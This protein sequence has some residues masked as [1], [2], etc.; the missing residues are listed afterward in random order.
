MEMLGESG[1]QEFGFGTVEFE[2]RHF[3]LVI[4]EHTLYA[5]VVEI[6]VDTVHQIRVAVFDR[7]GHRKLDFMV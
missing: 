6:V 2:E 5:L 4:A 7:D 3:G 1:H